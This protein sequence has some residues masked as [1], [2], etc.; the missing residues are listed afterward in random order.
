MECQ[1]TAQ[2]VL[3]HNGYIQF[4]EKMVFTLKRFLAYNYYKNV[5]FNKDICWSSK[6]KIMINANKCGS[7]GVAYAVFRGVKMKM[8]LTAATEVTGN[9]AYTQTEYV[10]GT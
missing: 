5:S 8:I 3:S 4:F 1:D 10:V 7:S 2:T 9:G 6:M